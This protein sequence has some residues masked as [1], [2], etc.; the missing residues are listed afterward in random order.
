MAIEEKKNKKKILLQNNSFP[1]IKKN[2][3]EKRK[4]KKG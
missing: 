3:D 1:L 2:R 4:T